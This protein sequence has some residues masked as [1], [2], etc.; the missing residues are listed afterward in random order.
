MT[1]FANNFNLGDAQYWMGITREFESFIPKNEPL[2]EIIH[3]TPFGE[4]NVSNVFALCST[5]R[6]T[7]SRTGLLPIVFNLPENNKYQLKEFKSEEEFVFTLKEFHK[8]MHYH[9]LIANKIKLKGAHGQD[10]PEECCYPSSI[11]IAFSAFRRGHLY[12]MLFGTDDRKHV[13]VGF[14]FRLKKLEGI[15][16]FDPT[17]DQY[18]TKD[19]NVPKNMVF[20]EKKGGNFNPGYKNLSP[21]IYLTSDHLKSSLRYNEWMFGRDAKGFL[22]KTFATA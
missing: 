21:G 18:S 1:A 6:D 17:S 11:N 12:T 20:L 4:T 14:P 3:K 2:K 22:E 5:E 19:F 8:I 7:L 9:Y 15:A 10:F 13:Y 16:L